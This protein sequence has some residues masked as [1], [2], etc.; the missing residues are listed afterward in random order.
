[1]FSPDVIEKYNI[2]FRYL[3]PIKRVQLELQYVWSSKVRSMKKHTGDPNFRK[4][5]LLRQQMSFLVDNIYAYLQVDVLE[6]QWS[7]L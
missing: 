4:A 2:L 7:K 5:M 3:L 6:S 1:M